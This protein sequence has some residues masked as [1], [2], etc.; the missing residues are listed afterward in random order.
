[1]C[2]VYLTSNR[3]HSRGTHNNYVRLY[4]HLLELPVFNCWRQ[5]ITIYKY[6]MQQILHS[7]DSPLQRLKCD[8]FLDISTAQLFWERHNRASKPQCIFFIYYYLFSMFDILT[9][10]VLRTVHLT[11]K[12][13]LWNIEGMKVYFQSMC[14]LTTYVVYLHSHFEQTN[15]ISAKLSCYFVWLKVPKINL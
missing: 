11:Q 2:Y 1:M 15:T 6:T 14:S 8:K 9:L 10:V 5:K 3:Y 7:S 13:L 4:Y 12:K